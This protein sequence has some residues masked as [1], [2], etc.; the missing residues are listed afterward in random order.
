MTSVSSLVM[1][2]ALVLGS[3]G[4]SQAGLA[5]PP[6]EE[7]G[8]AVAHPAPKLGFG[9][10]GEGNDLT[11]SSAC[12]FRNGKTVV[13]LGGDVETWIDPDNTRHKIADVFA[14]DANHKFNLLWTGR[15]ING[16]VHTI[17]CRVSGNTA[18][19]YIGGSF[20]T[21]MGVRRLRAAQ[22]KVSA[23]GGDV[24][25]RLA[26]WS[27]KLPSKVR[28]VAS[29]PMGHVF[30]ASGGNVFALA[31]RT[32]RELWRLRANADV[33][34]LQY[35]STRLFVGGLFS[36]TKTGRAPKFHRNGLV[37]LKQGTG[38][39]VKAFNAKLRRTTTS[40]KFNGE[41]PLDMAWDGVHNRLIL[42]I[43]GAFQNQVRSHNPRTGKSIWVHLLGGDGQTC[44][45]V[46]NQVF[47]GHHRASSNEG[48]FNFNTYEGFFWLN[49]GVQ[50]H[51]AI[52]PDFSGGGR[53]RD[54][55]N[56]GI[57]TSFVLGRLLCVGGA[58]TGP[59]K[60]FACF[61]LR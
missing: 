29:N 9:Q 60:K 41:I 11:S 46:R 57:I 20:T 10:V 14:V 32:G 44:T 43:G 59:L 24:S 54:G 30:V 21:F 26:S 52:N 42:C 34:S 40:S 5:S 2:V 1:A 25:V 13:F 6:P 12:R 36:W 7:R 4:I 17:L 23:T 53:N 8:V 50:A 33:L 49:D 56:N 47:V 39:P 22:L 61:D 27:P 51:F 37:K 48:K 15:G 38:R 16:F 28:A 58:F 55:R 35:R 3:A 45:V 19:V 18:K 31:P